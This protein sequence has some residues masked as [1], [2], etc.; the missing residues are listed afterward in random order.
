MP[1]IPAVVAELLGSL[2]R[3]AEIFVT[4]VALRDPLAFVS[5]ATGALLTTAAVAVLGYLA[6]GAAVD[7][8]ERA[9]GSPGRGRR[10][11]D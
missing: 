7:A 5:F 10:P 4:E 9:T 8:V 1:S 3:L 2:V 6:A 11:R